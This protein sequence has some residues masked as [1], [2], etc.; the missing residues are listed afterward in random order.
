MSVR[1]RKDAGYK[2]YEPVWIWG[3]LQ[4]TRVLPL[5]NRLREGLSERELELQKGCVRVRFEGAKLTTLL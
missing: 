4:V 3:A 1:T 5:E 2:I